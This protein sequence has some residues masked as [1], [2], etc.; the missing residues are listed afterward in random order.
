[1][2]PRSKEYA[3]PIS[4]VTLE[5]EEEEDDFFKRFWGKLL[6]KKKK[7]RKENSLYLPSES[8]G[9]CL[10]PSPGFLPLQ[11]WPRRSMGQGWGGGGDLHF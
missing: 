9:A 2:N 7:K 11:N 5:K 4:A 8:P 10:T 1:M 6:K 3:F